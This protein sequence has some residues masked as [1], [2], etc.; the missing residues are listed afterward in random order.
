VPTALTAET[1]TLEVG[2]VVP[3]ISPVLSGVSTVS[4]VGTVVAVL[5]D[6]GPLTTVSGTG[7]IGTLG[8]D[9]VQGQPLVASRRRKITLNPGV[10]PYNFSKFLRSRQGEIVVVTADAAVP[11]SSLEAVGSAG[12]AGVDVTVGLIGVAG[13]GA[14][15]YVYTD[16][17]SAPP[18]TGVA[19]AG[20][21]GSMTVSVTREL[22]ADGSVASAGTVE[23]VVGEVAA[24]S[25]VQAA[26]TSGDI[27]QKQLLTFMEGVYATMAP[28]T[29]T[30][31][32]TGVWVPSNGRPPSGWQPQPRP[33]GIWTPVDQS[34]EDDWTPQT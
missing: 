28:G 15:S 22:V 9:L 1:G 2:T 11:L 4:A 23:A 3:G 7:E 5:G 31:I 29:V 27:V 16:Q 21:V 18:L 32:I 10:T 14:V 25:G 19:G 26:S 12:T 8:V 30:P 13:A 33:Q 24:L 20:A 6:V 34:E 17:G